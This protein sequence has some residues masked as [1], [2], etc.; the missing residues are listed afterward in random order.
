MNLNFMMLGMIIMA[1][2][3]AAL[4][5]LRYWRETRDRFFLFFALAFT[6]EGCN[7]I[8]LG[9]QRY[10]DEQEPFFYLVRLAAF[11]LILVAIIDK[12]LRRKPGGTK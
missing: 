8:I 11:T 7:R 5:F 6:L 4:F 3:V 12:N 2:F 10:S 1:S 9:L